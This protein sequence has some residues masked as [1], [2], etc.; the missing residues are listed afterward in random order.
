MRPW[1][2]WLLRHRGRWV[3]LALLIVVQVPLS[4]VQY[5]WEGV[6]DTYR[7]TRRDWREILNHKEETP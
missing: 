6:R 3:L 2:L 7:D 4:F 5:L 1:A